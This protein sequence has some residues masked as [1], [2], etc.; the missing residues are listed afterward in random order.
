MLKHIQ[1]VLLA[2][3]ALGALGLGG[4]AIAGA[5]S[6]QTATTATPRTTAPVRPPFDGPA[7][8]TAAHEDAEKPVTGDA[9]VKAKAAAVKSV[10][11]G[12][13][14]TVTTDFSSNGYE[15]TVTKSDGTE[16][17]VHLDS[18]F[19]VIQGGPNGHGCRRGGPGHGPGPDQT[20]DQAPTNSNGV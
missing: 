9:A 6:S 13:A 10:G 20:P 1:Q 11:G 17:E 19:I 2:G 3:A 16:V 12:E 8:G 14:G 5:T 7:H 18:S 15:V 4:A